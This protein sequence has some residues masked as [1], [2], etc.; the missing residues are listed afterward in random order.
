[1]G[2]GNQQAARERC[3]LKSA[4]ARRDRVRRFQSKQPRIVVTADYR[5]NADTSDRLVRLLVDLLLEGKAR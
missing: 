5:P 2:Q 3:A 4:D 1:M